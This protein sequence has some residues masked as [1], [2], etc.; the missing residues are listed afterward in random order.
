M[1]DTVYDIRCKPMTNWVGLLLCS[2]KVHRT[3]PASG[4]SAMPELLTD[5]M[6]KCPLDTAHRDKTG[7]EKSLLT[8]ASAGNLSALFVS[9]RKEYCSQI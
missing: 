3:A 6:T 2:V 5:E 1:V 8:P 4:H 9:W 7:R